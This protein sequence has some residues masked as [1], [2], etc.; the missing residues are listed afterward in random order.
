MFVF[1]TDDDSLVANLANDSRILRIQKDTITTQ[2]MNTLQTGVIN[3]A[4]SPP[5]QFT[6]TS[7][8]KGNTIDSTLIDGFGNDYYWPLEHLMK[9]D[10]TLASNATYHNYSYSKTGSNVDVYILDTGVSF[11]H[12]FLFDSTGNTRV[13][14]LPGFGFQEVTGITITDP[15]SGYSSTPQVYFYYTNGAIDDRGAQAY[16]TLTSGSVTSITITNQGSGYTSAPLIQISGG[17]APSST[18]ASVE[19]HISGDDDNGHGTYCAQCIGG[20]GHEG[21]Y[22][23][24]DGGQGP[25]VAKECRF[26]AVKIFSNYVDSPSDSFILDSINAVIAHNDSTDVNYKGS[27]RPSIIN[28]SFGNTIPRAAWPRFYEDETGSWANTLIEDGLKI[29]T[30]PSSGTTQPVHVVLSAG[31]GWTTY[32]GATTGP[33]QARTNIAQ[34]ARTQAESGN[35]DPGQGNPIC[36]GATEQ[37]DKGG[38]NQMKPAGFSNYGSSSLSIWAPGVDVPVANWDWT[39]NN[40]NTITLING[41]SFSCPYVA[42]LL[43]LRLD[44][45]PTELP[46]DTKSWLLNTTTG[47]SNPSRIST[48]LE[49]T[50]LSTDPIYLWAPDNEVIVTL[51]ASLGGFYFDV[52]DVVQITGATDIFHYFDPTYLNVSADDLNDWHVITRT[53]GQHTSTPQIVFELPSV[54]DTTTGGGS[55]VQVAKVDGT[56]EATDRGSDKNVLIYRVRSISVMYYDYIFKYYSV[57]YSDNTFFYSPYQEYTVV[58]GIPSGSLGQFSLGNY[59]DFDLGMQLLSDTTEP[60]LTT[61]MSID[62]APIGT[63]FDPSTGK[64]TGILAFN[65]TFNFTITADNGYFEEI[66]SYSYSI[67]NTVYSSMSNG[68]TL[69]KGAWQ[70]Y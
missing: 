48:L 50:S 40:I 35:T 20:D 3:Q 70:L 45:N 33:M 46:A 58:G 54:L 25:G 11:H 22:S 18:S 49:P 67:D 21:L 9:R 65:G 57:D 60:Y 53:D 68:I 26:Y 5:H 39:A 69:S 38:D 66:R 37:F 43:A 16:V 41:T 24:G 14:G 56:F 10:F 13:R 2:L 59:I 62:T 30:A 44:H 19:A 32:N 12:P 4:P 63:S 55:T 61:T 52:G 42:G 28:A 31:N 51:P 47:G 29:A 6:R 7:T 27:T 36:V 1:D 23:S 64:L 15:G 34:I 8:V 17:G